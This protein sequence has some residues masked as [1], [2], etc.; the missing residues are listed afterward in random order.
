MVNANEQAVLENLKWT[1]SV[2]N[3]T[4]APETGVYFGSAMGAK[5][6]WYLDVDTQVSAPTKNSD[7]TT[8]Y[9]IT[10]VL[11]NKISEDMGDAPWYIVGSDP[12]QRDDTDMLLDLYLYAPAGGKITNMQTNGYFTGQDYFHGDWNTMPGD[13]PMTRAEYAGHEVWFGMTQMLA[14]TETTLN[15]TVTTAPAAQE[16]LKLVVTPLPDE[17]NM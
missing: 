4:A 1:N 17:R 10:V 7:G 3:S 14:E 6:N 8:S 2:S 5:M 9:N 15:Y 13:Q 11:K 16:P 12:A